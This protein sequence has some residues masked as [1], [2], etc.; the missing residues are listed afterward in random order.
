MSSFERAYRAESIESLYIEC[1][2]I[3][4]GIWSTT[5]FRFY[6]QRVRPFFITS[7]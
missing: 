2:C 1:P 7:L 3:S 4:K 5:D 6:P